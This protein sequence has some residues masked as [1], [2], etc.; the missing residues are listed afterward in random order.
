MAKFL[1]LKPP[2]LILITHAHTDH[3]DPRAIAALRTPTTHLIV[4]T[5]ARAMLL[6]VQGAL[7]MANGERRSLGGVR[8]R[9]GAGGALLPAGNANH[10]VAKTAPTIHDV[11]LVIRNKPSLA[12]VRAH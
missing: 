3:L 2:T 7:T 11:E 5:S 9:G 8:H 10:A 12:T 1:G 6:D 4:P